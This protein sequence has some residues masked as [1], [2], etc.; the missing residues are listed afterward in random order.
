MFRDSSTARTMLRAALVTAIAVLGTLRASIGDGLD[1]EEWVN[2]IEV[3]VV[4]FA[5]YLGIGA[6][7]PAVEP[8]FGNKLEGVE[9][10]VPPATVDNEESPPVRVRGR[11]KR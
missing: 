9:V 11:R 2:L 10:P 6:A 5:G 8:F 7:V 1:T 3:G 4:A